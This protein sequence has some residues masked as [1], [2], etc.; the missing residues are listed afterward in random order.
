[1]ACVQADRT[2]A[3]QVIPCYFPERHKYMGATS[4]SI[5]ILALYTEYMR[6]K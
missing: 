2:P 4:R 1:M 6:P 5:I 3:M